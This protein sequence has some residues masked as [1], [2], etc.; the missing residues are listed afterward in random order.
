M[1]ATSLT[2]ASPLVWVSSITGIIFVTSLAQDYKHANL[3]GAIF[4]V[5]LAI[6]SFEA[7]FFGNA[8]MNILFSVPVSLYAWYRSS[9]PSPGRYTLTLPQAIG[10]G[11][12]SVILLLCSIWFSVHSGS[13]MPIY[14]GIS[15]MLPIIALVMMAFRLKEQWWIWLLFNALELVMWF[16]ASG[17]QQGLWAVFAMKVI[18]LVNSVIGLIHWYRSAQQS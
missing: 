16:K 14:D 13:F 18:F 2:Q 5:T 1:I 4:S 10:W 17:I 15:T 12:L 9:R 6:L 8:L 7:N 11:A 3:F